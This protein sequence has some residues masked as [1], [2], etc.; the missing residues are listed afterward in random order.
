MKTNQAGTH[1]F[2]QSLNTNFKDNSFENMRKIAQHLGAHYKNGSVYF[3][4]WLP[5]LGEDNIEDKKICLEIL[6]PTASIDWKAPNQSI[7]F[8]CFDC[9]IIRKEA[10]GFAVIDTA[11]AGN[12][13]ETGDFYSIKYTNEKGETKR[14]FDPL[15]YSIPF[16]AFAPAEIY[17]MNSM[18]DNRQDKAHFEA[19]EANKRLSGPVNILQIH[20]HTATEEGTLGSLAD[21]FKGISN[22][23][24]ESLTKAEKAFS[25]YDGVQLLPIMPQIDIEGGQPFFNIKSTQNGIA[26]VELTQHYIQDWGYDIVIAAASAINPSLLATKRPHEL[27]EFIETLHN[28]QPQPKKVILD[29]VYGHSDNQAQLILN[30][31]FFLGSGMYGQEMNVQQP[32]VRAMMLES[33]R[34][35]GNYGVDGFRVDAAQDIVYHDENGKTQY[36]N[37]YL[38]LMNEL[39]YEVA[40]VSYKMWMVFEDGRPWPQTDW[41]IAT[42]YR[43]VHEM[44]PNALQ[45]GPLTFVNNKPLIFGFWM[46]RFWRVNQI[47]RMG[48]VW[49][50]GGSNHD[51]YRGLAQLP[52]HSTNYNSYLGDTL[53]EV[54]FKAYNNPAARLLDHAFLPG[55][56]MEFI[57]TSTDT[58]WGFLRNTDA[59]WG[60]K[61]MAQERYFFDWFVN[62]DLYQNETYFKRLKAFG[63]QKLEGL[64]AFK[65]ALSQLVELT[66]Y[67]FGKMVKGFQLFE[68]QFFLPT[69]EKELKAIAK[70]YMED[71]YDFCNVSK[72]IQNASETMIDFNY[73][74]RNF[75]LNH[76][77]LSRNLTETDTFN[78]WHS[79]N[80]AVVY[81]GHRMIGN[82]EIIVIANM[83]GATTDVPLS[84]L[85]LP[86]SDFSNYKIALKTPNNEVNDLENIRLADSE[87]IVFSRSK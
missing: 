79:P 31:H 13:S 84:A 7:D 67:N 11:K 78:Y 76:P 5:E 61:V 57:N 42:T 36:D 30:E 70:A 16:G 17:D 28:F 23:N 69:S 18:F 34:R 80:G 73:D 54:A 74:V 32:V 55:V 52:P 83:E 49:V 6:R 65:N 60:V 20:P 63:Y 39:V 3:G 41:N 50:T 12:K 9:E 4:F 45:W 82:T 72:H 15:S 48:E 24:N 29:I 14:I 43:N 26:T 8:E 62:E 35:I 56:P 21:F 51:T 25:S 71:A 58:P 44:Y 64:L 81:Y 86:V 66:D 87:G 75:R 19:F 33:Q 59:H 38:G 10:F 22:K 53:R 68:G 85:N 37:E 2:I 40:G 1:Q 47:A 77:A 46:E 27:L